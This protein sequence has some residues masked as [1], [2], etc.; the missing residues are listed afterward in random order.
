MMTNS[1]PT[2]DII[3]IGNAI[4]D[5]LAPC[6]DSALTTLGLAKG[7]MQLIDEAQAESL[8]AGMGSSTECSGGSAANTL[9]GLAGLGA[10]CAFIGKVRDDQLGE[11]FR[12]DLRA[13]GVAFDT[14]A[15]GQGPATARCLIFVTLDAQ[16][17]MATYLGACVGVTEADVDEALIS[18]S[19]MLYIEGYLWD[20]PPVKAAI[21]KAISAAKKAGRKVAFTLSDTFCVERHRAEFLEL[22]EGDIDILF[23]N[24]HELLSLFE[25]RDF[26]TACKQLQVRCEVAA[27]TRSEKGCVV[28]TKAGI[29]AHAAERIANVVDTTGAG[30]LFASGFLFGL[31]RGLNFAACAALGN[32]CAGR[33]IQQMGARSAT[34]LA[35]VLAKHAA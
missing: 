15:A 22:L 3:A 24:E 16:R 20:Q 21:R 34:P 7:S 19:A 2:Y 14:P 11:I 12:H 4:V 1:S 10:K 29:E 31:S 23:A 17:T 33:I 5:V 18:N 28:I 25:A 9:A 32:S 27:V 26:D 6:T 8:Y 30:D 35:D 13:V